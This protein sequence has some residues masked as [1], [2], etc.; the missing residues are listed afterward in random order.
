FVQFSKSKFI[1]VACFATRLYYIILRIPRQ[2]FCS[3]T[4]FKRQ[5]LYNIIITISGQ[6]LN[7]PK[8]YSFIPQYF[9]HK[10]NTLCC[11]I[12]NIPSFSKKVNNIVGFFG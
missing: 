10:F 4:Y 6:H 3:K 9:P 5:L 2:P 7:F 11:G 12:N 1:I 8:G